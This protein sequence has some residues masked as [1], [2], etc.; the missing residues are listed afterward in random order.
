[1]ILRPANEADCAAMAAIYAPYVNETDVSWEY[2]A[3]D[4]AEMQTR[5]REHVAAG[6]PWLVAEE[7]G[8]MLGYAYA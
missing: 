4:A 5:L 6:Y 7:D 8:R 1:M 3:P 2:E